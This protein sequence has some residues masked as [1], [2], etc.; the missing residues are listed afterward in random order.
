MSYTPDD[1]R[2]FEDDIAEAFA[3]GEIKA[4]IHLS[5]GNEEYLI[6]LFKDIRPGDWALVGW[7]SHYHCLLKGVPPSDLK[8]AILDGRSVALNFPEARIIG[9]GIVGGTPPIAVG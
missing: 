6:N 8:A 5:G 4:P 3:R 7:R 9:S 1:L 2:A